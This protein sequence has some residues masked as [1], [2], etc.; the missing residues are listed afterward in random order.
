MEGLADWQVALRVQ[1]SA[2]YEVAQY[3]FSPRAFLR[4]FFLGNGPRLVPQLQPEQA[5]FQ[6]I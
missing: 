5:L 4:I 6:S 1:L 2:S 3:L